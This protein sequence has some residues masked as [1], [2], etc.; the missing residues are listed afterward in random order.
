MNIGPRIKLARAKHS[1]S[2]RDLAARV[3]VSPAAISKLE[4]G[5]ANPRQDTLLKLAKAL[6]VGMEYFFRE[7]KVETCAPAY[8]KNSR[9]GKRLS[10]AVEAAIVENVERYLTI[11]E[12]LAVEQIPLERRQVTSVQDA[13]Q[14]ANHLRTAWNLGAGPLEDLT[15]RLEDAGVK[16]IALSGPE[17]F[18]GF[19]CWVNGDIPV[20]A[21]NESLPGDRQRFD[22]AHELGHLV[23][24]T[25]EGVDPERA[26]HRFAG[27]FLVN[28]QAALAELG[29]HRSNIGIEELKILKEE[30]GLSVQAWIRRSY[31]L[32]IIDESTYSSMFKWLSAS[33]LRRSEPGVVEKEQPH[34]LQLLIHRALAEDLITPSYAATLLG[35]RLGKNPSRPTAEQLRGSAELL[36]PLYATPGELTDFAVADLGGPDEDS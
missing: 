23:M 35:E 10:A 14:V 30:Y 8:R 32:E 1:L 33:G 21:F 3:G 13:E 20:I 6:S 5:E 17:G 27:A 7:I 18:D 9:L 11:E 22:L 24:I 26:A 28:A 12:V 36:A 2:V 31:D 25:D 16:V 4:R 15:G 29:R 34:R 19:S